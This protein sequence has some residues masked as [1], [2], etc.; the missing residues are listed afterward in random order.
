MQKR[1]DTRPPKQPSAPF[2]LVANLLA[3]LALLS[4][5]FAGLML[6]QEGR[7]QAAPPPL[8]TLAAEQSPA[9]VDLPV[10]N[11]FAD[12]PAALDA[13]I[14]R[15][16][17]LHTTLPDYS[18]YEMREY[19][20]QAGDTL[21]GI[22]ERF[23]LKPQSLMFGNYDILFDDPHRLSVGQKLRILPQD[24]A[25]Y[26][27]TETDGLNGVAAFFRVRPEDIVDWPGNNLSRETVGD[28]SDPNIEPGTVLFVPNGVRDFQSWSVPI[29]SRRD[30]ARA[31]N[32]GPGSCGT[33]ESGAVG[34]GT[35]I[36]PTNDRSI[37]GYN[38]SPA[39]NHNGL[40][41]AGRM[42]HP[43]YASDG[44][45]VVYA[46]WNDF[47]YGNMIVIDH[48]TGWQTLYAHLSTLNVGCGSSVRQG[49]VIGGM[50]STGNSSGPHLHFELMSASGG[51]VNPFDY[52][53]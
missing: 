10:F 6:W 8:P 43:I 27:W 33:I 44:G 40:D 14:T 49:D 32:I 31:R 29:I 19:E 37:S 47:G 22:A 15:D 51:K 1:M 30:P 39:T 52:L 2:G 46:G 35:F 12:Q 20:V 21:F 24:G 11:G 4:T 34:G 38:Y 28:F 3:V 13:G 25:L 7:A 45:V 41:F 36:Y 53:Q 9:A 26:T 50:G 23:G 42:G 16:T 48:G 5:G 18:I 17:Q